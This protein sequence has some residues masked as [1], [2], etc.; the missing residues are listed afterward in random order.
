MPSTVIRTYWYNR[1][2]HELD[3]IFQSSLRYTYQDVP[4]T[5]YAGLQAASSKGEFFNEHIRGRFA[6][7][8]H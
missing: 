3:I 5:L 8:R 2:R 1:Q 6:F 4:E 7:T